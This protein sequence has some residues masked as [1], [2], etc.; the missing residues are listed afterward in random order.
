MYEPMPFWEF[1]LKQ[2]LI[3]RIKKEVS[4]GLTQINTERRED[5]WP[6]RG[7]KGTKFVRK[8]IAVF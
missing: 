4:H 5:D 6:Q 8:N 2:Q 7:T 1:Q 3:E